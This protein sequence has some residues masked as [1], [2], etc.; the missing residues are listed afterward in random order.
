MTLKRTKSWEYRGLTI[1]PALFG[2]AWICYTKGPEDQEAEVL[3]AETKDAM[4]CKIR[5]Y[6]KRK[7]S[8]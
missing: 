5:Q 7:E 4:M 6:L 8:K 2:K 3:Q 1:S